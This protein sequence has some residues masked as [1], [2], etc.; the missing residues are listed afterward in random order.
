MGQGTATSQAQMGNQ[1]AA[2][3]SNLWTQNANAQGAAGMAGANARQSGILG[4]IQAGTNVL[5]D[6]RLKT[7]IKNIGT[8]KTG[9]GLY[10]WKYKDM[11]DDFPVEQAHLADWGKYST[12][13]MADEVMEVMPEAVINIGD[14]YAVNYSML[15]A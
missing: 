12:G 8:H 4:V 5:S 1:N 6:R 15:E 9:I 7:D 10:S 2:N 11:P 13:V 14:Y 3:L